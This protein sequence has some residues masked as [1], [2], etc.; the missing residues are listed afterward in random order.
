MS[1]QTSTF[2]QQALASAE[3]LLLEKYKYWYEEDGEK[4]YHEDKSKHTYDEMVAKIEEE[5]EGDRGCGEAWHREQDRLERIEALAWQ[6][7]I[8]GLFRLEAQKCL[9]LCNYY[10]SFVPEPVDCVYPPGKREYSYSS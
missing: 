1:S 3:K 2:T 4:Q 5:E 7:L 8:T 6:R 10:S 9:Q